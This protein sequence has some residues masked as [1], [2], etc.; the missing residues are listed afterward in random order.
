MQSTASAPESSNDMHLASDETD[1]ELSSDE[2]A[3]IFSFL[4]PN[5]IMPARVCTT[6][7]DAAKKTLVPP[8]DPSDLPVEIH[9]AKSYNAIRV[10]S[11]A[12]P[13]LEQLT[14]SKLGSGHVYSDGDDPEEWD[15]DHINY[16][17]DINIISSFRK[18]RILTFDEAPLTGRYPDLFDFPLLQELSI[19]S[20]HNLKFDLDMLREF[21]LLE[22]LDFRDNQHLTGNISRLRAFK[23]TLKSLYIWKCLSVRGNLMEMADFPRLKELELYGTPVT[24]DI[25]NIRSNDFPALESLNLPDTVQGGMKYE[26]RHVSEVPSFMHTVHLLSQRTPALFSKHYLLSTGLGWTLSE[27]SPDWYEK[28]ECEFPY[29]PFHL[30]FVRAGSRRGWSWC[31]SNGEYSCE[32]N[33]LDPEPNSGSGDYGTYIEELQGVEHFVGFYRGY[34]QPPTEAEYRRLIED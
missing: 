5:D 16:I 20:C 17:H 25:R 4:Q 19:T 11:T 3:I 21:P 1:E 32:I 18:L 26:F 9:D 30:Q 10:M 14:V 12:L 7:R 24:G 22:V 6:W 15:I 23:G 13:N 34:Y 33:W 31:S 29:P 2:V 8:V 28:D 27:D